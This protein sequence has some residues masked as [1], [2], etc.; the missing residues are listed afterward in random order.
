MSSSLSWADLAG[1]ISDPVSATVAPRSPAVLLLVA[2]LL[3]A[4]PFSAQHLE[5][6]EPPRLRARRASRRRPWLAEAR[7]DRGLRVEVDALPSPTAAHSLMTP[8]GS[9][10]GSPRLVGWLLATIRFCPGTTAQPQGRGGGRERKK[11][12]RDPR[13]WGAAGVA[14]GSWLS[15]SLSRA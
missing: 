3:S 12:S 6:P 11:S 5:T 7:S 10:C 1:L 9:P 13:E 2:L 4:F 15:G 8:S 14:S